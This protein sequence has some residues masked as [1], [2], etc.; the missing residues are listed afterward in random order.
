MNKLYS[1]TY[2]LILSADDAK[3]GDNLVPFTQANVLEAVVKVSKYYKELG[4]RLEIPPHKLDQIYDKPATDRHQMFVAALFENAPME[5]LSWKAVNS[6]IKELEVQ[7]WAAQDRTDAMTKSSSFES[8]LSP[9]SA[10]GTFRNT[11]GS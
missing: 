8:Q 5:K 3:D 7:E 4:M 6:S 11:Q 10:R 2:T 9:I 1:F